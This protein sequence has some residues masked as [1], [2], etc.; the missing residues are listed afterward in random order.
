MFS[1]KPIIEIRNISKS[2]GKNEVLKS[3]D[4]DILPG[5]V[6]ALIGE[7]GAGKTTLL[8]IMFG[9]HK[10][11]SGDIYLNGNL[12]HFNSPHDAKINGISMI[13]QEPLLF[14]EMNILENLFIGYIEQKNR[15]LIDWKGLELK[16]KEILK[17]I[18]LNIPLKQKLTN[19]PFAEQQLIEI[20][21]ALVSEGQIIFMDEPSASLTPD[22][23]ENLLKIIKQLKQEGKS[24]VYVSHRLEEIKKIA[25]RVTILRDGVLVGTYKNKELSQENMIQL[26]I[27][28]KI[29]EQIVKENEVFSEEPYFVVRNISIPGLFENISFD[30]RKGEIF[31]IA[32]LVG[33]GRTEVARAIFGITPL[34]KGEIF[35]DGKKVRINSSE[36]A[37]KNGIVLIPEDRQGLGLFLQKSIAFNITFTILQKISG[38]FGWI[39]RKREKEI[40]KE[41]IKLLKIKSTGVN[42]IVSNL[43]GGNQQKVSISKWIVT[44]PSILVL[45]EPTKGIDVG[46]KNE[47]YKIING[48]ANEGR[49]IIMISSELYE[50]LGL[51]DRVMVMYEGKHASFLENSELTEVKALSAMHGY[52]V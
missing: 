27:G 51:C 44:N 10:Q 38:F 23:V 29:D 21:A 46:S 9:A 47:L 50:I 24:I 34:K 45:D 8:N 31:G 4:F 2:F 18:G 12:V 6:H 5:E 35:I 15:I 30:V 16:A 42:Q 32:G 37:I 25:D 20:G 17:K 14:K 36:D 11:S 41:Y 28:R 19:I 52:K 43:S 13:H 26:M 22:E 39:F 40:S 33:A 48:L 7:N 49:C 1:K 3:I